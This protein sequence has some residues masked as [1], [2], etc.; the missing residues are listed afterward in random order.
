MKEQIIKE[1]NKRLEAEMGPEP[2]Y[3]KET[4]KI[5]DKE[6]KQRFKPETY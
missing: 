5:L 4:V 6:V 3:A 1:V 2:N